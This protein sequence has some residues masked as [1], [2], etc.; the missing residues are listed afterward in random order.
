M[1]FDESPIISITG[2]T[3]K[4]RRKLALDEVSLEA[5]RGR[6]FG[7]LGENGAGKSTLIKHVLG[8]LRAK[9]GTVRVFGMDPVKD[10]EAVL[11]RIGYLSEDREMPGWMRVDELMR[12]TKAFYPKWDQEFAEDLRDTFRLDRRRR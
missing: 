9:S 7:L 1:S 12:F 6:V 11:G 5:R 10:A 4:F 3:R 2:L 8:S